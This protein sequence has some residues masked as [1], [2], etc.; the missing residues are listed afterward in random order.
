MYKTKD[1]KEAER[2]I[3]GIQESILQMVKAREEKMKNE[4]FE[5]LRKDY[6][7]L[8]IKAN[9][10]ENKSMKISM[11]E[12]ITE[13]RILYVTGQETTNSLLSWTILLLAIHQEWQE[14]A[15]EEVINQFGVEKS[16]DD[17]GIA[18]LKIVGMII[19][20]TLRLYSPVF[21]G[22]IRDVHRDVK[23]GKLIV[24]AGVQVHVPIMACHH[25][26]EIWGNDVHLFKPD[27]FSEGI[28]K[29]TNNNSSAFMPFGMGPH[30][31]VG[32]N[33]AMNEAKITIAMILQRFTFTLSHDYI[34]SPSHG[35]V[36]RPEK[37]IQ[38]ILN[39]L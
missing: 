18:K 1:V 22:F 38:V 13:C 37:G 23:L 12:L 9:R 10:E 5:A 34:H 16:L 30:M 29:A 36:L 2:M 39:A 31:C 7:G 15:R 4:E 19:H 21:A 17:D 3:K 8:L 35:M 26:R 32:F 27:R 25:D 24:P 6:L 28:V 33:F 20:E 14:A 11:E